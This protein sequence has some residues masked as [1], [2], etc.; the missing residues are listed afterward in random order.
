LSTTGSGTQELAGLEL[1][2]DL[3]RTLAKRG[4]SVIFSTQITSL[5]EFARDELDSL[6]F[7]LDDKH[8]VSE[9]IGD[10]GMKELRRRTGLEKLLD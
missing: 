2:Q 4:V 9:G 5:A 7:K 1:G 10:G 6:C 3:L 8:H